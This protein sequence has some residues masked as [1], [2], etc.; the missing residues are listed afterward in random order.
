[1]KAAARA[2]TCR[3]RVYSSL[4]GSDTAESAERLNSASRGLE[5]SLGVKP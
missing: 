5:T 2:S 1:M 4:P 3:V